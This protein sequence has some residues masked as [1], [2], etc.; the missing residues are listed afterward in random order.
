VVGML[1]IFLGIYLVTKKI[2]S[3]AWMLK[4]F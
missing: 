3:K 2:E 1:L 4:V